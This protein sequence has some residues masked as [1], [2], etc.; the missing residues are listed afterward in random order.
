MTFNKLD[1]DRIAYKILNYNLRF[2]NIIWSI[3]LVLVLIFKGFSIFTYY[4][5]Y[6]NSLDYV[7][8][9]MLTNNIIQNQIINGNNT[10]IF[11]NLDFTI[12][13][14]IENYFLIL[15]FTKM[16]ILLLILLN[17]IFYFKNRT[18]NKYFI[19]L[20]II[21]LVI[22][23]LI[24]MIILLDINSNFNLYITDFINIHIKL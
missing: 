9:Y 20:T 4:L 15:I 17:L 11:N 13:S 3:S 21:L 24:N 14:H 16:F 18:I 6:Q 12:N 2:Y 5:L 1:L 19:S 22:G 10:V 7:V 23:N 8:D